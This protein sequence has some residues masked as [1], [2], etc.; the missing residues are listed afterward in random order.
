MVLNSLIRIT[1]PMCAKTHIWGPQP[2]RFCFSRDE[3]SPKDLHFNKFPD[4]ND[5]PA[6]GTTLQKSQF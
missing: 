2:Q 3:M 5:A 6:Q 4:G 1:T